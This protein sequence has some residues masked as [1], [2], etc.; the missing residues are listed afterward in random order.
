MKLYA[1]YGMLLDY[2][3]N[4]V[5]TEGKDPRMLVLEYEMHGKTKAN[6]PYNNR[7]ISVV[8]I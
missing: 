2:G 3:D 7:F 6:R 5:V 1:G 4:L 8:T